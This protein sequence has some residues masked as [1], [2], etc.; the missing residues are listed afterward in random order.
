MQ[1]MPKTPAWLSDWLGGS[2][3]LPDALRV[4]DGLEPVAPD[5]M[6]GRWRGR[7]L[8]T[9]HPLDG[10]LEALGWYGKEV[11]LPERVHPLLFRVRGGG[12]VP[13]EPALM[14][15]EVA[16]RWPG[17]ARGLATRLA[18]AAAS[19]VL[20]ARRHGARLDLRDFREQRSVAL[21]YHAQPITDQ[22]RRVDGDRVVGLMERRGMSAPFFF[23]LTRDEGA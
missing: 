16:L 5:E 18:F 14:P 17:L 20:R 10:L 12:V 3:S 6:V 1:A 19:P 15:T 21:V 4:F 2:L 7:T 8:P 23:L 11:E 13:M 22:L 9:G